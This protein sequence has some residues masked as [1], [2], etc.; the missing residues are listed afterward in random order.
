MTMNNKDCL[1]EQELTLHYYGELDASRSRHLVDCQQCTKQL[2]ALTAEL[3]GLPKPDCTADALAGVRMAARVTEQLT[4][5]RRRRWLPA[6]GAGAV[7]ALALVI[8]FSYNLQPEP[9]QVTLS[10]PA[11]ATPMSLEEDMPDIDFLEDIELLK[12]LDLLA[13]IEGV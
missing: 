11:A 9:V 8:T 6:L 3:A 4:N 7:A 10:S 2:E 13:Q 1:T 12:E 5:R